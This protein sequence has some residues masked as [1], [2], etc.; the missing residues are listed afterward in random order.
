MVNKEREAGLEILA[1]RFG[2][3]S[4]LALATLEGD[5]PAVLTVNGYYE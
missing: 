3:D 5:R 4:L 2:R 1:E